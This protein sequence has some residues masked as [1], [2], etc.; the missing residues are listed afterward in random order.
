MTTF[1]REL[2]IR[3]NK[4]YDGWDWTMDGQFK[5]PRVKG[6][7]KKARSRY[8]RTLEKRLSK[9]EIDKLNKE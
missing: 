7:D 4:T 9:K 6:K 8:S 2:K 5:E 1:N 3:T